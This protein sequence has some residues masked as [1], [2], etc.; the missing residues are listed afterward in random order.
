[1]SQLWK[2]DEELFALA[3]Q[4]LFVSV[5]GDVMDKLGLQRQFLPPEVRGLT[6]EMVTIGRAMPVLITDAPEGDYGSGSTGT[7][8]QQWGL[9]MDALDSLKPGEIYLCTG[10]SPDYALWG[11]LMS[12]RAMHCGAAGAVL[13]GYTRDVRGILQLGFPVFCHGS[14]GQDQGPRGKTVDYRIP[15]KAG[16]AVVEP[17]DILFGDSDGVCVVP[18][19][20]ERDVFAGALEK[21]R[22]EKTVHQEILKGMTARDAFAKYGIL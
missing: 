13:N 2:D 7:M 14:Y 9:M 15:V 16:Q 1:M 10:G 21:A 22:G 4:E 11:E 6:R 5:V 17:G 12:T 3:K 20:A 8:K 18:R 19:R